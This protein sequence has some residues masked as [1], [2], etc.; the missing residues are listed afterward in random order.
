MNFRSCGRPCHYRTRG[1]PPGWEYGKC[2]GQ[3]SNFAS[4]V[5]SAP[6]AQG[7]SGRNYL[8][9]YSCLAIVVGGHDIVVTSPAP[10]P[11][12]LN[13]LARYWELVKTC[14]AEYTKTHD[15]A[16]NHLGNSGHRCTGRRSDGTRWQAAWQFR[17]RPAYPGSTQVQS[18]LGDGAQDRRA[19]AAGSGVVLLGAALLS[20]K[21]SGWMW[22]VLGLLVIGAAFLL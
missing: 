18:Q 13:A 3:P 6:P 19:H 20:T 4:A 14:R 17:R 8:Q 1:H 15:R 12:Q 11:A 22:L 5:Q 2:L 21:V 7:C 9:A 16:D 10:I